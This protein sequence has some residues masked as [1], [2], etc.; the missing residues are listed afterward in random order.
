MSLSHANPHENMIMK[1]TSSTNTG[2]LGLAVGAALLL[3][4]VCAG[5]ANAATTNVTLCVR[6]LSKTMNDGKSITFWGYTDNC[7]SNSAGLLPGPT[8]EIGAGDTLNLTL[9]TASA[10][11]E[12]VTAYRGHTIHLYGADLSS[13]NDG[14]PLT[15]S[16]VNG[17]AY[18]WT[19][20]RSMAG[21]YLYH[22]YVHTVKHLEMGLY[23]ALI[24]RPKDS[25]GNILS[26]RLTTSSQTQFDFEQ[27]LVF[28]T[29]DPNY[30]TAEGDSPVFS[31]YN[32]Q[33]F[34]I[35]GNEGPATGTPAVTLSAT[36][37]KNVAL[38]L[39]GIHGVGGTFSILSRSGSTAHPF[40]VYM[41][42]GRQLPSPRTVTSLDISSGQ[43]F[44]VIFT[45][46]SSS[47]SWYP[48]IQY[49]KLRD[50]SA[51]STTYSKV[52]F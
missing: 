48:Q 21:S 35:N 33:Y 24:V 19:P 25:Q 44:D 31:S 7:Q 51:Y 40:T 34:L 49:K 28:S 15:G 14:V 3:S 23:G 47:G 29:V 50:G 43:R 1:T 17:G 11:N 18:T 41:Q 16:A 20:A 42:D 37:N 10:P 52:T 32:P 6:S 2:R 39:I 5:V 8:L 36:V 30:H 45:T 4:G 13:A 9:N 46:P 27:T 26:N 38:R 22:D 12:S